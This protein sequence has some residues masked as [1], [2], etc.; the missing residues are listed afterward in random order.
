MPHV[1]QVAETNPAL[2]VSEPDLFIF[3]EESS[4]AYLK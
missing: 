1:L 4:N 2:A 3:H